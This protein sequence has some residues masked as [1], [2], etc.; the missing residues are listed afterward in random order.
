V[1]PDN[2]W[3]YAVLPFLTMAVLTAGFIVVFRQRAKTR[4]ALGIRAAPSS[5]RWWDRPAVPLGVIAVAVA[6]GVAVSPGLYAL[7]LLAVPPLWRRRPRRSSEVD[8][9]TNG[10]AHRD[11]GAFTPE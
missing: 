2:A 6:L 11:G 8:P 3:V 4:R 10:H 1:T 9:R 5:R 7:A